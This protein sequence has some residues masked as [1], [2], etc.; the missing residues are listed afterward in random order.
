MKHAAQ[1][2]EMLR[3]APA[4]QASSPHTAHACS[5]CGQAALLHDI[6]SPQTTTDR[7]LAFLWVLQAALLKLLADSNE[8]TQELASKGLSTLYDACDEATQE[9]I[10]AELVK[11]LQAS[12]A[13]SASSSG[14]DMATFSELSEIANNAGQP[15]L[16]YKLMELSTASAVRRSVSNPLTAT[17]RWRAW[18]RHGWCFRRLCSAR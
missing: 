8:T 18:R 12:R 6:F 11:G 13:A 17:W 2:P 9:T 10:V 3:A 5:L 15:E 16:V 14:G 7:S 4:V 1:S